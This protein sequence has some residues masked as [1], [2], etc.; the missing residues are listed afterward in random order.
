MRARSALAREP[1]SWAT[2]IAIGVVLYTASLSP[3]AARGCIAGWPEP[4]DWNVV[5]RDDASVMRLREAAGIFASLSA[6]R[7]ERI[8]REALH[9]WRLACL[10]NDAERQAEAEIYCREILRES[11][12]NAA[13]IA[14]ALARAFPTEGTHRVLDPAAASRALENLLASGRGD[15]LHLSILAS[16]LSWRGK[17]SKIVATLR[18]HQHLFADGMAAGGF[19]ALQAEARLRSGGVVADAPG[20]D[21]DRVEV[22]R[23]LQEADPAA[24]RDRL[25]A[26]ACRLHGTGSADPVFVDAL[27]RLAALGFVRETARFADRLVELA[28]T[29]DAIRLAAHAKAAYGDHAAA[30]VLLDARAA[31]FPGG[32]LPRNLRLL[33]AQCNQ[34]LG[35]LAAAISEM[36]ALRETGAA[37]PEVLGLADMYVRRGDL[38]LAAETISGVVDD[39]VITPEQALHFAHVLGSD[40]PAV[41]TKLWRRAVAQELEPRLLP[42][43]LGIAHR[44]AIGPESAP[45]VRRM[46]A[47]AVP[48]GG[49]TEQAAVIS[50]SIDQMLEFLRAR[51]AEVE[52]LAGLHETGT[53]PLH[54]LA[55]QMGWSLAR[56]FHEAPLRQ[57]RTASASGIFLAAHG[58]RTAADRIPDDPK[59]WRLHL[60]VTAVLMA[61]HL[62]LLDGVERCFRPLRVSSHLVS[63][64]LSMREELLDGSPTEAGAAREIIAAV[65]ARLILPIPSD[66][67]VATSGLVGTLLDRASVVGGIALTWDDDARAAVA[68]GQAA[69]NLSGVVASLERMGEITPV[70]AANARARLGTAGAEIPVGGMLERGSALLCHWNTI[71]ELAQAGLLKA[72]CRTLRM[73]ADE[74]FIAELRAGKLDGEA[75]AETA[76]WLDELRGRLNRGIQDGTYELLPIMPAPE[77]KLGPRDGPL[78]CLLDLLSI[79]ATE[80]DVVWIDDRALN[81]YTACGPAPLVTFADMLAALRQYGRLSDEDCYARL[82]RL[83][84]GKV[85]FIPA[86]DGELGFWLRR[87]PVVDGRLV[88]T[89]EL[90]ALRRYLAS[91]LRHERILQIPPLPDGAPNP[92]GEVAFVIS[93]QRAVSAT[94]T[95]LW[96]DQSLAPDRILACSRWLRDNVAVDRYDRFPVYQPTT[97]GRTA[98]LVNGLSTMLC[99]GFL[100][101]RPLDVGE[102]RCDGYMAWLEAEVVGPRLRA[103]P[104]IEQ[105]IVSALAAFLA[106]QPQSEHEEFFASTALARCELPRQASGRLKRQADGGPRPARDHWPRP[107]PQGRGDRQLFLAREAIP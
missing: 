23:A 39:A 28:G 100:L 21:Q 93:W 92:K 65:E 4:C 79:P 73:H 63:T 96:A 6:D 45:I 74:G 56:L 59:D 33:R 36:Q 72:A 10:A 46:A 80:G 75:R 13:A 15:I 98:V 85:A 55:P 12:T 99:G 66:H 82:L 50:M 24:A 17:S 31:D 7:Q 70:E 48:M 35:K 25:V 20:I 107:G 34:Q 83:R 30:V 19:A 84:A 61:Q 103:D 14:W 1:D 76:A 40:A 29:A 102:N 22:L 8:D 2:R 26:V 88:E 3:V 78:A 77:D 54:L 38:A 37:V 106:E 64:L 95:S 87:A 62:G 16:L 101:L 27:F 91:C 81:A 94:L 58:G 51:R 71:Q 104:G 44:L 18:R 67:D 47:S 52:R 57:E 32:L 43:A 68:M 86:W 53:V 42:V 105:A 97:E 11:P 5:R 9:S 41:A 89:D 90:A 60:D 49:A 69:V